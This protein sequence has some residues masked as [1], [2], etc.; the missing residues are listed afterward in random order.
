M[1]SALSGVRSGVKYGATATALRR[2][3][4]GGEVREKRDPV[5]VALSSLL[6]T[7]PED[8]QV[9]LGCYVEMY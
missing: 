7:E 1:S 3:E 6:L 5:V 9:L 2:V 8:H 4:L